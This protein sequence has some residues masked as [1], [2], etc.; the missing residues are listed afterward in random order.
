MAM[1]VVKDELRGRHRVQEEATPTLVHSNWLVVAAGGLAL[2]RTQKLIL[3]VSAKNPIRVRWEL[4]HFKNFIF[5]LCHLDIE[6]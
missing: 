4:W 2:R 5:V 3:I 6:S 1:S